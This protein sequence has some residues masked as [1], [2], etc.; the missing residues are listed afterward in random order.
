MA[1]VMIGLIG[2]VLALAGASSIRAFLPA[3]I[4]FAGVR[5][6][7]EIPTEY[8]PGF[9]YRIAG[10]TPAWQTSWWF[11]TLLGT[12]SVLE[13]A[14][15]RVPDIKKFMSDDLDKYTKPLFSGLLAAGV[16]S[17]ADSA[18]F[19]Q[20]ISP[21]KEASFSIGVSG[22]I[23]LGAVAVTALHC[24]IRSAV[25]EIVYSIDP[26][27]DLYLQTICNYLGEF[28][29][30]GLLLIAFVVPQLALV[31]AVV[32]F[33]LALWFK[34]MVKQSEELNSH[35]CPE[36]AGKGATVR[37]MNSAVICPECASEQPKVCRVSFLGLPTSS[38]LRGK[39]LIAHQFDLLMHRR[40]RWCSSKIDN[41]FSCKKCGR[42]Q[43]DK[44]FFKYFCLRT[45]LRIFLLLF[46]AG[47]FAVIVPLPVLSLILVA[48]A[49]NNMAGLM[50][51]GN[52]LKARFIFSLLKIFAWLFILLFAMIPGI[53]LIVLIP[54]L[55]RCFYVRNRVRKSIREH[56]NA[57]AN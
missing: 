43:W 52:K 57:A 55:I 2:Q 41:M 18:L 5:A 39:K 45:D 3:F 33:L 31:L 23:V 53:G 1:L 42:E 15:M 27:N 11:L 17:A 37:V 44:D 38:P 25:L 47:I 35:D 51:V 32:N 21:V 46:F 9:L 22:M 10:N 28:S 40:C 29:L 4:Y 49:S 19:N 6:A 16:V 14:A 48:W 50:N 26:D 36:C 13:M 8:V 7:I 34:R 56:L 54:Y 30:L 12:L 20:V 24:K